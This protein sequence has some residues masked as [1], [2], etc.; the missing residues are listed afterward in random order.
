MKKACRNTSSAVSSSKKSLEQKPVRQ[1]REAEEDTITSPLF[2]VT[3][4]RG[5]PPLSVELVIDEVKVSMELDT[6]ATMS[7][8]PEHLF[9]HLWPGRDIPVTSVRLCGYNQ[10]PIPVVAAVMLQ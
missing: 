8:M 9:R 4:T 5:S 1:I 6:G 3:S 7:I 2:Q 10:D